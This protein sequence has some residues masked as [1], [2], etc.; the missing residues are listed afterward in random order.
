MAQNR[1]NVR[2]ITRNDTAASWKEKDPVLLLGEFG[3]ETDTGLIK[4][5]DDIHPWAELNYIN[6][7]ASTAATHYEGTA[8]LKEDGTTYQTDMEVIAEAL[9]ENI[10]EA[11]DI[12]IVKRIIAGEKISYTAYI[13]DGENWTALD[14]NYNAENVFFA[15]D[16][17]VTS[18]IGAVEIPEGEN[19][20]TVKAAGKSLK[21]VLASILAERKYPSATN[22][23]VTVKFTCATSVEV[24]TEITPVY[25]ATLEP[26]SYTYGPATGIT[27][28][29]WSITDNQTTPNTSTESSGSFPKIT[30]GDSTN[31]KVT[32][33][34]TYGDGTI[35]I[36]NLGDEYADAQ[37]KGSSVSGSTSTNLKGYRNYFYGVLATTT[38]E[39]PITSDLIRGLTKG[40]AGGYTTKRT[41]TMN[42]SDVE[43]A[44]R[45]IIAYPANAVTATR[46]GLTS[47]ILPNSLNFDAVANGAYVQ[48]AN[49]EVEGANKYTATPYIVWLYEPD[50][51][52]SSEIHN[53]TLA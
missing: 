47:V 28:T 40:V 53:A 19:N 42:A 22:P 35:P 41:F 30:I 18:N 17:T 3:F 39:A 21:D 10:A 9:G 16:F 25:E 34:A 11:D 46:K 20:T 50:S 27:A 31:Y 4:V 48:Q 26:G 24:G 13:Y 44:K 51:I 6:D 1:V 37:I 43:G 23:S 5:G 14:G 15:E 36:D 52:D 8:Q 49:V 33:T 32:A 12:C 29:S 2:L 45:M 38:A 7:L